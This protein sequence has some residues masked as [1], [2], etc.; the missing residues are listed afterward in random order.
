MR[1]PGCQLIGVELELADDGARSFQSGRLHRVVNPATIAD[2]T[3]TESLGQSPFDLIP[4]LVADIVTVSKQAI[5]D[6]VCYAFFDLKLV[7]EPSGALGIAALLSGTVSTAGRV[8]I[9][10]S[11]GNIDSNVMIDCLD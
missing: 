3:R 11:G 1:S 4:R 5:V 8:S 7:V 2:G 6:A 10:I 9:L